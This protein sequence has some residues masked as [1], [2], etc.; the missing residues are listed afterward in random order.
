M[1]TY[2]SKLFSSN[3]Q[4]KQNTKAQILLI[5]GLG[6]H[7]G[8]YKHLVEYLTKW[9]ADITAFD[10]YG[11][12]KSIG[13]RGHINSYNIIMDEI[14]YYLSKIKQ[15]NSNQPVILYGHSMGGNIVLNFCLKNSPNINAVI[16]SSPAI[17][18]AFKSSMLQL[19]LAKILYPIFPSLTIKNSLNLNTISR[20]KAIIEDYKKDPLVHNQISIKLGLDIIKHGEWA[21][22]NSHKLHIP[23]LIIHGDKDEITDHDASQ[24]FSNNSTNCTFKSFKDGYHELHNDIDKELVFSKISNWIST[25]IS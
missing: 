25:I 17:H 11:H 13:K 1:N 3:W 12:G 8:R 21:L 18:P 6:D 20:D 5:H 23:G 22:E 15:E 2:K 9:G 10:L 16:A 19:T 14:N 7:S 4:S 24:T